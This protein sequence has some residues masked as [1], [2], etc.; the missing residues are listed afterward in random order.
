MKTSSISLRVADF[1]KSYPPFNFI[2]EENLIRL[3]GSGKVKFH[4]GGEII[5]QEG[6]KRDPHFY[7]IQKGTVNLCR[8]G[9]HGEELIDIRAEGN[10]LGIHWEQSAETYLA[11]AKTTSDTILYVLPIALFGELA[12]K[13]PKVNAFLRS[14]YSSSTPAGENNNKGIGE[15]PSDWL[16]HRDAARERASR[17]LLTCSPDDT[18]SHVARLMAPGNQEALIVVN[19]RR[20]PLGII[21]ESDLCGKVATGEIPVTDSASNLMTSPVIT[22]PPGLTVGELLLHMLRH[23]VHHL[24]VTADGTASSPVIGVVAERDLSLLHGRL[25]T[26]LTNEIRV[27]RSPETLAAARSR[28]DEL[29]L[30]YLETQAPVS[31]IAAYV[32]E[33]DG[34]LTE[35]ALWL[36]RQK[37]AKQGRPGPGM[38]FCWLAFHSEGRRERLLRSAQRTGLVF[39]DP[40]EGTGEAAASYYRELAREVRETLLFCGF[41]LEPRDLRADNPRWCRPLSEWKKHYSTWIAKPI[42]NDILRQTPFF[43]LRPI[44]GDFSLAERLTDHIH[45]EL[46]AHPA[47]I[48]LLA[49]DA[50]ANLPPVTIFRDSVMDKSGMLWTCIDT[51]LHILY[52]LVDIAR[53][54]A[55]EYQLADVPSTINRFQCIAELLPEHA[56]LLGDAIQAINFGFHLQTTFGLRHGN[57]GQ[58]VRPSDLNLIEREEIK[59]VFRT[60]ARMLEF[61]AN[62]FGL[63]AASSS[64]AKATSS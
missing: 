34:A 54:L 5:F 56:S 13:F 14:Y 7:V 12:T 21:T 43:D 8:Q 49:N 25:P 19:P 51:K 2:D 50:I 11:T 23:R 15:A 63:K 55:L 9:S 57:D 4:E 27:A 26:M 52:P 31:W 35:R 1:L 22:I 41:P 47:F 29:V 53:V 32:S 30:H 40:E 20:L 10:L 48:P 38:P 61:S 24:C 36:A 17:S 46:A 16:N 58:F 62:H 6:K 64:S 37:L 3:A 59:T 42:E 28:A 45:D 44:A 33:I 18:I 39:A 60:V